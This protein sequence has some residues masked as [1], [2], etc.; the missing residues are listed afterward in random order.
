MNAY[1]LAADEFQRVREVRKQEY[2][3]TYWNNKGK[4]QKASEALYKLLEIPLMGDAPTA[5]GNK[6][7][8]LSNQYYQKFNNGVGRLTA[9]ELDL[10]M[11]AL[12]AHLA[13]KYFVR[14][15]KVNEI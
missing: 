4:Y 14:E 12:V 13:A 10:R 2:K 7:R 3:P 9:E 11:D 8:R 1:D 15:V 5:D 6:L